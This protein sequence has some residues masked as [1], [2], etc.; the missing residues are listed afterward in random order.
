MTFETQVR[1]QLLAWYDTHRR[2]LPWRHTADPYAIW[3]SEVMLQQTRVDTVIPYYQRWLA[4][5][6]DVATLAQAPLTAV[7]QQWE[8]LG[9]YTRARHLHRCAQ[10][11]QAQGT[12]PQTAATWQALPGIGPYSAAAIAAIVAQE[13][14]AAV[15]GNVRRLICRVFGLDTPESA[16]VQRL[17][18]ACLDPLRPGD[19][20]QA[21]MDLGATLCPAR[22]PQCDRCPLQNLCRTRSDRRPVAKPRPVVP[23]QH[24]LVMIPWRGDRVGLWPATGRLLAGTWEF[25]SCEVPDRTASPTAHLPTFEAVFGLTLEL[26]SHLADVN[27]AYSHRRLRIRAYQ[28]TST[29]A[30]NGGKWVTPTALAAY[31]MGKLARTLAQALTR[32]SSGNLYG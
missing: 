11:I 30:G 23:L 20:N 9:Y 28:A 1:A 24:R 16:T 14:I 3:L 31:P 2:D 29:T 32:P 12:W 26:G 25:P 10:M 19:T 21:W 15:D 13:P 17:A 7:L 8:G 5:F 27:H 18:Q 6:P 22:R 4:R